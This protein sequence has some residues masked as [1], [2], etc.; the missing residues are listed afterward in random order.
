MIQNNAVTAP[1]SLTPAEWQSVISLYRAFAEASPDLL[2]AALS[3]DWEDIPLAPGQAAGP[4]G[5]KAIVREF[6]EAVPDLQVSIHDAL[7]E[8]GR[9]AIRAEFSGTHLGPFLG[10]PATGLPVRMAIHEFH[11]VRGGRV[12][13]TWHLEDL[14]G[15]L[16]QI[17]AWPPAK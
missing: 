7:A 13:R 16:N 10:V 2:D 12:V 14:F 17:G 9:V 11:E 15:I 5:L 3:P 1:Q 6:T 4:E 8:G